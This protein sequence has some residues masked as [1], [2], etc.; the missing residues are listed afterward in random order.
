MSELERLW[1]RYMVREGKSVA[2]L[3]RNGGAALYKTWLPME[4]KNS[5]YNMDVCFHVWAGREHR[6]FPDVREAQ[7]CFERMVGEQQA[8]T[9]IFN[10]AGYEDGLSH[11]EG[12]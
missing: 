11:K 5:W 10:P 12:G 8:E 6:V 9:R 7:R 4:I 1:L 2:L 3:G